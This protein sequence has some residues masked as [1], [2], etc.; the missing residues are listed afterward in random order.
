MRRRFLHLSV[1][2]ATLAIV[3][4]LAPQAVA[5][6]GGATRLMGKLQE[7]VRQLRELRQDYYKQKA[8]DDAE[9]E[10]AR[11]DGELL[12]NQLEA[13][14]EQEV[15]LDAELADYRSQVSGFEAELEK[16]GVVREAVEREVAAFVSAQV[17]QIGAG[18]PYKQ[19]ERIA[20][21]RAASFDP[22]EAVT[23]A[24]SGRLGHLWSYAQEELRLAESSETYTERAVAEESV[25][26]YARYFRVGQLMLGYVTEDGQAA[27]MWLDGAQGGWWQPILDAK[28]L[29]QLRDAAE[30]LDRREAPRFVSLPIILDAAGE[31]EKSP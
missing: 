20:R 22:N 26:P 11:R 25:V 28:Q 9:I 8:Q 19:E 31:S 14:R 23:S 7:L 12:R 21:A 10:A 13:L 30:I 3:G 27:A 29:G 15:S 18:I 16:K 24:V 4:L 6:E 17:A 5:A 2:P 1:L